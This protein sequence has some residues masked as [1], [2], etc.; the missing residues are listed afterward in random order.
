MAAH[1]PLFAL[2]D[3]PTLKAAW[4]DPHYVVA[5]EGPVG[6]GKT[7]W[8]LMLCLY[9]WNMMQK[10]D[11][12]G[13]RRTRG[14]I[15]RREWDKLEK[16]TLPSL[17]EWFP[18]EIYGSYNQNKKLYQMRWVDAKLGRCECDV[19]L[20]GLDNVKQALDDLGSLQVTWAYI[21]EARELDFALVKKV[22]ERTE[23]YPQYD[24]KDPVRYPGP[25]RP[26]VVLETNP[27]PARH[28]WVDMEKKA[29]GDPS[30]P[31]N[32]EVQEQWGFYRQPPGL[33]YHIDGTGRLIVDGENPQRE[34]RSHI[35]PGYYLR[36]LP[37]MTD[38]EIK[39]QLCGERGSS[40]EGMPV[41]PEYREAMHY[42]AHLKWIP[43][44]PMWR[45]W[46][47]GRHPA[48][49]FIQVVNGHVNVVD[50]LYREN[51]GSVDFGD[52]VVMK[53][54][55]E[56]PGATWSDVGD[57]SGDYM[58]Q[59]DD[60]TPFSI[61]A[62]KGIAMMP[63]PQDPGIRH[64]SVRRGLSTNLDGKPII[65]I[66]PKCELVKEALEGGYRY[67]KTAHSATTDP[68][69]RPKPE[70]NK[71]SNLMDPLQYFCGL[72]LGDLVMGGSNGP[73]YHVEDPSE[74]EFDGFGL[75]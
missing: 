44:I 70:K 66:G 56:F 25:T 11:A 35:K 54:L 19:Y 32:R 65:Q 17:F 51:M 67:E 60:Q 40:F 24:E 33:L 59:N 50:E 63:G 30:D 36:K 27:P 31:K 34:N 23:R 10:P 15:V 46:D 9:K 14:L 16:T 7:S 21:A 49:L 6:S 29:K 13:V 45:A 5:V 48:C 37:G 3:S 22:I 61:L 39:V 55:S 2:D 12:T 43:G 28:W 4:R 64:E 74:P 38:Q 20:M 18:K 72:N 53:S 41:Y 42:N 69:Y 62:G 26:G 71:W 58:G 68:I 1:R 47:F 52:L 8:A 75:Y 57:P 73:S